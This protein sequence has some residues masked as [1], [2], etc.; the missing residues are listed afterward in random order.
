MKTILPKDFEIEAP[1]RIIGVECEYYLQT[2][3]S[4]VIHPFRERLTR[5]H[6]LVREHKTGMLSNGSR[7]YHDVSHEEY[8]T[9]E[10]LGPKQATEADMAGQ[11]IMADA[12]SAIDL[13]GFHGG[14]YRRSGV[15]ID[16]M[17]V[18]QGYHQNFG[19]PV[20]VP[21]KDHE[22]A[23]GSLLATRVYAMQ[24]MVS[25]DGYN[26][27][28]KASGHV[29]GEVMAPELTNR[30]TKQSKPTM[31]RVPRN[32]EN[33]YEYDQGWCRLEVRQADPVISPTGQ[34]LG[35]AAMS[36]A[37]RLV[38]HHAEFGK[39][40]EAASLR[41]PNESAMIFSSDLT[42]TKTAPNV[43]GKNL[44]MLDVQEILCDGFEEFAERYNLPEDEATA[45]E[46][47]RETIDNFRLS[48]PELGEYGGELPFQFDVVAKH[49]YLLRHSKKKVKLKRASIQR[50]ISW[51]R[52]YKEGGAQKYWS[53]FP[54]HYIDYD[55]VLALVREPPQET[56]A[57]DRVQRM[58][59]E[60]CKSVTWTSWKS[61]ADIRF[62]FP[63]PYR[64]S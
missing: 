3:E 24:G 10:S 18:T 44:T 36:L 45:V 49:L 23:L 30:I 25:R 7:Q 34:F 22:L 19:V 63:S 56:R 39:Y 53:V 14:I 13:D 43:D 46:L 47:L 54:S 2:E 59:E 27:S 1:P 12:F 29:G 9:P 48:A 11:L 64:I 41:S 35:L 52:I 62:A 50:D 28:Q 42:L 55:E 5:A 58:K 40:L 15:F 6:G 51:D 8:A 60:R 61:R 38:E 20:S 57:Y 37:L 17:V 26:F 16:G 33:K 32:E 21:I 4:T 31:I